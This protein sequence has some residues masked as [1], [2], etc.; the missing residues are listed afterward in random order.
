MYLRTVSIFSNILTCIL[1]IFK[2]YFMVFWSPF[3]PLSVLFEVWDL[4]DTIDEDK[5]GFISMNDIAR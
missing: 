3:N 1:W 5:R 2:L 4:F